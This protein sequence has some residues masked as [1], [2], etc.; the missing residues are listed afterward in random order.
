MADLE[1]MVGTG[2]GEETTDRQSCFRW[3]QMLSG[4][5]NITFDLIV[6]KC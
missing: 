1:G 4:A 5:K 3:I 2:E 6:L